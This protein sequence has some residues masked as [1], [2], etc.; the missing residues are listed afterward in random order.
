M[1]EVGTIRNS[2]DFRL[3][4]KLGSRDH[5]V[6]IMKPK[7]RPDWMTKKQYDD[8]PDSIV[9]RELDVGGKILVTTLLC[10]KAILKIA[11]KTLYRQRWNIELDIRHI[12]T[13]MGMFTLSCKTPDMAKKEMWVYLLAYKLFRLAMLQS[14]VLADVLPRSLR[15]KHVQ[16][17]CL[18]WRGASTGI[19]EAE[20]I[21]ELLMLM[22]KKTVGKRPDP[23]DHCAAR[24]TR[25]RLSSA[26]SGGA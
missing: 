24:I 4:K 12:K 10:P 21:T 8:A 22:A 17:L 2:T 1:H 26:P 19:V 20:S 6:A 14:A 18:A 16:Q 11:L 25:Q 9:T 3:G 13:T 23:I 5:L 15:F 7:V